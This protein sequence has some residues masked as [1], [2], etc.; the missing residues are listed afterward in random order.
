MRRG[1]EAD[2]ERQTFTI[3]RSVSKQRKAAKNRSGG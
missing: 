2:M 1:Q 3:L